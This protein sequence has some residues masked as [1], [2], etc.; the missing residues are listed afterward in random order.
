MQAVSTLPPTLLLPKSLPPE[1]DVKEGNS[2]VSGCGAN[3]G[4]SRSRDYRE[5]PGAWKGRE[6]GAAAWTK[7]GWETSPLFPNI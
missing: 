3:K 2:K 7:S 4:P 6:M 5:K 1:A